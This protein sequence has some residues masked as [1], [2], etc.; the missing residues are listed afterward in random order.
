MCGSGRATKVA[1]SLQL[2][3]TPF[4]AAC[5]QGLGAPSPVAEI[6]S[7]P[8]FCR[9][10]EADAPNQVVQPVQP[11]LDGGKGVVVSPSDAEEVVDIGESCDT[12]AAPSDVRDYAVRAPSSPDA[13]WP[14]PA[15]C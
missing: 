3:V 9:A 15:K 8:S 6:T 10:D 4:N 7:T 12:Q 14:S 11:D 2:D 5:T 1:H 13:L